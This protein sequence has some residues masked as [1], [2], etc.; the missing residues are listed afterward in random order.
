M[1]SRL[2]FNCTGIPK[3][4]SDATKDAYLYTGGTSVAGVTLAKRYKVRTEAKG[5]ASYCYPMYKSTHWANNGRTLRANLNQNVKQVK[6]VKL[7]GYSLVN[8]RQ[9]NIQ[10]MHEIQVDDARDTGGRLHNP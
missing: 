9:P 4:Y 8:Q 10:S 2:R 7:C 6:A 5:E 3:D 1:I